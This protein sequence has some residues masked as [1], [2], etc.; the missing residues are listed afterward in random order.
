MDRRGRRRAGAGR[1]LRSRSRSRCSG[2]SSS[3]AP[4]T[5]GCAPPSARRPG[6]GEALARDPRRA[7][8]RVQG[9]AARDL[10][11]LRD[12]AHVP[13][14]RQHDRGARPARARHA[15]LYEASLEATFRA[16]IVPDAARIRFAVLAPSAD[17]APDSSLSHM[18]SR[19]VERWA[20]RRASSSS[21]P[22]AGTPTRA[23]AALARRARA[24]R[25]L[26]HRRSRSC[27]CSTGSRRA[28]R[29]LALPAGTRVMET[30]GFKGR[31][32]ELS[33]DELHGA[34]ETR[35]GVPRARIVNQYGMSEL[36]SQFYEPCLRAGSRDRREAR[37][38][39]GRARARSTR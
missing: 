25:A 28:A 19:A 2:C 37:S 34:I 30:G 26:R 29:S 15:A 32:R 31:S 18:F 17:E 7:D 1:A 22:T 21:A 36:G 11:G 4:R 5:A 10:P 39:P 9:G 27:T 8:G 38:R 35:L 23:I 12:G 3:T 24:A 14:Q 33:R 20:R 16:F 13:H 6:A